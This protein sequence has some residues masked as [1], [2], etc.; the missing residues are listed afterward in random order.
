M[1]RDEAPD[2]IARRELPPSSPFAADDG[3]ADPHLASVLA[4]FGAGRRSVADV[5]DALAA[6]RVLVPVLAETAARPKDEHEH[7]PEPEHTP[8]GH[9]DSRAS[10]GI[11][12]LR[13]PDGRMAL[14]VFTSVATMAAWRAGARPVP[15]DV[16]RA[17][18]SALE[19]GWEVLV[20][21][22]GG[23]VTMLVPR[24]A[25]V[26][27]AEGQQ[28]RPAVS[29][30][31]VDD[32]IRAAVAG[33]VGGLRQVLAVD[34]TPGRRAEVAVVLTLAA[35]LDRARLDAV[36]AAVNEALAADVTV[37]E[38]VDSLELRPVSAGAGAAPTR[39]RATP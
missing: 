26:A 39:A 28:W 34:V 4:A 31:A 38:R 33:A 25:V 29:G 7:E 20:V 37:A 11:V 3:S 19:E 13:A 17:A 35:G 2:P 9:H 1:T 22:P 21:D 30:G 15:T 36:L 23:P 8:E 18:R 14:P 10:A 6:A 32:E 27:L 24:P 12:A 16:P 5:V